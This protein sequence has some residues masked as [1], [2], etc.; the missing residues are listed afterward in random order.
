MKKSTC[1]GY[2]TIMSNPELFKI[3]PNRLDLYWVNLGEQRG[4]IQGGMRPC[5]VVS[6]NKANTFS[7][8]VTVVPVTTKTKKMLPT[9]VSL[10]RGKAGI[11]ADSTILLEQ[12]IP[13]N[14][15]Q[16]MEY[17][18]KIDDIEIIKKINQAISLQL[19]LVS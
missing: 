3:K 7:P 19:G 4:H 1:T 8:V 10:T 5:V 14:K 11:E 6:N 16:L 2:E 18:G 17:I 15:S 12:N 9:H 13:I